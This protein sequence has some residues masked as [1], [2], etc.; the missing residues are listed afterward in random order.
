MKILTKVLLVVVLVGLAGFGQAQTLKIGYVD[1]NELMGMMP[2]RDTIENKLRQFEQQL[3]N[4]LRAMATEYQTKLTDYQNNLATMSNL[5]RQS[6]EKELTD[7]QTRIQDFQQNADLD[8]SEH[9]NELLTPLID[10]VKKAIEDV[11]TENGYTY[12][13]DSATG[14][15]LHIGSGADNVTAKVKTKLGIK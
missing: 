3:E 5:I 10:K 15:L 4:E 13:I 7:L 14:V 1:S 2:E 6:K 11:G 8:Y 12:I 9:R